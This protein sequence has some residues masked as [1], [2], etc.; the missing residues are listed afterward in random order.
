M[1][2]LRCAPVIDVTDLVYAADRAIWGAAF[3]GQ[4]LAL[5][6]AL[7]VIRNRH[8]GITALLAAVVHQAELADVKIAA[9][10]PAS[11]PVGL[12]VGDGFLEMVEARIAAPR[13]PPHLV[14]DRTLLIPQ[15]FQLTAAVVNDA[16]GRGKSQRKRALADGQRVLRMGNASAD[17]RIDVYVEIRVLRQH[18]QLR[19]QNLEALL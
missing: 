1:R 9:A 10:R 14:P 13:Q 5:H 15:W 11:P 3:L 18:L 4:E 6:V 12:A 2:G 16:D 7:L 19:V 8:T 17:H